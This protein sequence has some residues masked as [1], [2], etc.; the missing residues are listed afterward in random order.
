MKTEQLNN[1]LIILFKGSIIS[2]FGTG[3]L[4]ILNYF[5]RRELALSLNLVDFGFIYSVMSLC[6]IFLAYLDMGLGRSATILMS[7]AFIKDLKSL[8]NLYYIQIFIIKL[9]CSLIVFVILAST[10]KYWMT[11][12]FKHS[13]A[14][15]F[16]IL[17]SLIVIQAVGTA[18]NT[19]ITALKKFGLL[20][21][22]QILTPATILIII[23]FLNP[24]HNINIY[25]LA[26][27]VAALVMFSFL[28]T[29]IAFAGYLPK[30]KSLKDF[31]CLGEIFH[32]SKWIA[33]SSLGLTT[34]YYMDSLMLT[35]LDGLKAVGLYNVALPIMQIAQSLMVIPAV[36]LPIVAGM[37]AER[38][39]QDIATI[40]GFVSEITLYIL[41]PVAFSIIL[42]A[43]YFIILLFSSKFTEATPTLMIL[44]IGNIL[45]SLSNFYMGTLNAGKYAKL[46]AISIVMAAVVN[47]FLNYIL[48]PYLS[49]TGA[50]IAT[51]SSY[52]FITVFLFIILKKNLK[53]FSL[54]KIKI[55]KFS[56]PGVICILIT[57]LFDFEWHYD[58]LYIIGFFI[59]MNLI[60][61]G[62]TF[63]TVF[64]YY[65]TGRSILKKK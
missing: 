37:W 3:C 33:I 54:D 61:F 2:L 7:K 53:V 15:P 18:P 56:V 11:D 28:F 1:H 55:L 60:Y 22:G 29:V 65:K 6:S 27:P 36:F 20:N 21:I 39:E 48:I 23:L 9:F 41:W 10:Y 50:A 13:D 44:F 4:G 32:L 34:M 31:F 42:L 19:V 35:W 64:G 8:G 45:F 58:L 12:F 40:C 26:F 52:L 38:K 46:V 5:I 63:K 14:T 49:I 47:I 51:A 25:A 17:L 43:K 30:A 62:V 57:L 24:Y 16:F 59:L